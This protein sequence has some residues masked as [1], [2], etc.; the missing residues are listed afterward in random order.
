M[1]SLPFTLEQGLAVAG[2][3][4]LGGVLAS[5]A[6][7]KLG[8]PALLLFLGMGMLAGGDGPGGI[9]FDNAPLAGAVGTI[10]LCIILFSGGLETDWKSVRP[11]LAHGLSLAT[12]GVVITAALVGF[13]AVYLLNISPVE[14]L[15]IGS[16]VASTD[17]AAVFGVLRARSI[18]IKGRLAPL[19]ELESGLNDPMAVFLTI[20]LTEMMLQPE[21]NI[22]ALVPLFVQQMSIGAILGPL[23]GLAAVWLINRLRL[24][25]VGL[26]YVATTALVITSFG[27]TASIGGSGFL[28]VYLTGLTMGRRNFLYKIGLVQFHE[29]LAWF[30][31]I[32]MFLIFGLQVFPRQLGEVAAAGVILSGVLILVARPIAVFVSLF[33]ER[34]LRKRD[35][36]FVSWTGL[37]GATPIILATIP[38]SYGL[39]EAQTLFHLVFFV[40]LTSVAI[41]G[42]L[43][44]PIA[45]ALDVIDNSPPNI[46]LK[47]V[48]K[49]L[50]EITLAPNSP[51]VGKQVVELNLPRSALIVLLV[52]GD[53]SYIPRGSTILQAGDA[54]LLATRKEDQQELRS[55]FERKVY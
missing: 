22:L 21:T 3:L 4:I 55:L 26:Y 41:Q 53:D 25:Y 30:M 33:G 50:L 54:I 9:H 46:P 37:R 16:I 23:V 35:K 43:L 18:R 47:K 5:K 27:L 11:I 39:P 40:V 1:P 10:A 17:A 7:A 31:Q 28:A 15:L 34:S 19:L 12:L 42:T 51:A 44:G 20:A 13:S 14:G 2:L 45:K 32:T 52:R 8:V 49:N 38:M 24:E 48:E 29:G 6:S 36:L